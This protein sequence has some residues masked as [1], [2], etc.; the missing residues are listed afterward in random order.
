MAIGIVAD[1]V[2]QQHDTGPYHCECPERLAA[3]DQALNAWPGRTQA[4]YL[5]LRPAREEELAR[6]HHP[7]HLARIASTQGRVAQLDPDTAASPRSFEVALLAAGSLLDLCDAALEQQVDAGFAL[8]RPPGHHATAARAMG[9]CLFNN[10]AAA[11]AHLIAARGLQRVLVVDWDV[12]HGN[13]TEDIFFADNRV[14]YFSTHQWPLYPGT[15]PVEAVGRGDG[16]GYNVNVPLSP[17]LGD[18]AYIQAFSRLLRP[19]AREYLPQFILVSAG[20]DAHA[21]DP[22][23]SMTLTDHG[24]A[25]LAQIV[26]ELAAEL[27]PGRLVFA[28]E[29]GYD[30]G[31]LS[32]SVVSVLG[33]LEGQRQDALI[34]QA[35][36]QELAPS[37]AKAR[38]MALNYWSLE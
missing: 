17:G 12:H 9:F 4:I 31:A 15:G 24:F 35:S 6:V 22:L 26:H 28:L 19:L 10:V 37:V 3:V 29:G 23:G 8:V 2:F 25:A 30:L 1:P 21:D 20:F 36:R 7:S 33:A 11:A 34:A 38:Q 32:R 5:P 16:E 27:C 14:L 13:G 18:S